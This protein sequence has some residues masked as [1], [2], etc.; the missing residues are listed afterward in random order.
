MF[1]TTVVPVSK[2]HLGGPALQYFYM[3]HR[4]GR[5]CREDVDAVDAVDAVERLL[6]RLLKTLVSLSHST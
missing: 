4:G 5:L 3:I 2:G 6:R 1:C